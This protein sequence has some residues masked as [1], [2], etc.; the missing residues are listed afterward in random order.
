MDIDY[1][2]VLYYL[3]YYLIGVVLHYLIKSFWYGFTEKNLSTDIQIKEMIL[4][5]LYIAIWIGYITGVL[6][7][8]LSFR[9][10]R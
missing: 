8:L 4:Y 10:F 2:L 9:L 1:E 7:E 6:I 5:P 3:E